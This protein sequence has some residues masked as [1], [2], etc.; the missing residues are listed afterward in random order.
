MLRFRNGA[1]VFL[2][3]WLQANAANFFVRPDSGVILL[4]QQ[5]TASW[6]VVK[7][8]A[9]IGPSDSLYLEDQYYARLLLGKGCTVLLKG[10]LR[11]TI[12]GSDTALIIHLD[13]GQAFL[14]RD[15]KPE[16]AGIKMDL[17]GC[18]ITPIG[19]AA[20]LK[21]TK[22]GEPTV[23]VLAGRVR[24]ESPKGET[25]VVVPGAYATYDPIAGSFKQGTVPKEAVAVLENWS[26]V[27]L[28]QASAAAAAQAVAEAQKPGVKDTTQKATQPV[29]QQANQAAPVGVQTPTAAQPQPAGQQA[30]PSPAATTAKVESGPQPQSQTVKETAAP[31][32]PRKEEPKKEEPKKEEQK[33]PTAVQP[34][35][36]EKKE[37]PQAGQQGISWELS[38]G[39]VTVDGEQWTRIAISPDIPIWKFGIGLDVELFLDPAGNF[40]DKGWKFDRDNWSESLMRKIKYLRFGYENDPVF[41]KVGGLSGVT[42]GYGFV[43]DRFTNMLHY[44]DQKL[45]GMQLY[46]N[47]IGPASV[48]LQTMIADFLDFKYGGGVVAGRLAV[49]P[50]KTTGIPLVSD[51]S[52]GAT[53]GIDIN[54]Y[55]PAHLWKYLGNLKD[56]NANGTTDWDWAFQQ[57]RTPQDSAVV[58]RDVALGIVDDTSTSYAKPDTVY[59]DSTSRYALFGADLG[60]PIIKGG[61][62]GLDIYGQFAVVADTVMFKKDKTG[63]GF[64]APGAALRAGPFNAR[65]EY[66]H[67]RGKFIP[68]Y[69]GP[70]YFDER[71]QRYPVVMTRSQSVMKRDLDGVFGTAGCNIANVI[72][73]DATY[74][75]LAGKNNAKDQRLETTAGIGKIV[76]SRIPKISKAEA[77]YYKTDIGST[78]MRVDNNAIVYDGFFEKTPGMYYGYRIGFAVT[79]NASIIW[80][81]RYG[82]AWQ[83]SGLV[84]NNNMIIQTA[85]T[86]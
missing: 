45:L 60:M 25:F 42:L 7:D 37:Q 10:E 38:A 78:A 14:K 40:S 33:P 19:T 36:E 47:N 11:A 57:A 24:M 39:S 70:Y 22:Q 8:S 65:L 3:I 69:F 43:V 68:G 52:V 17:R 49:C 79:Q 59:R 46:L 51:L 23:A 2:F 34:A 63:W 21:F 48:T 20:A 56:K 62:V 73:L 64:G 1:T 32:Q 41:V 77:Y 61:F 54:E 83:G 50:M 16:L 5:K 28:E 67:L 76:L 44:P 66:R 84:Q 35:K 71:L 30:A 13:Q 15:E 86:F 72:M 81:T 53:Y 31:A 74:Q 27:K 58:R 6:T 80:D 4:W 55:A 82:F 29:K 9:V 85:V 75:Y 26:G 18:S 12:A